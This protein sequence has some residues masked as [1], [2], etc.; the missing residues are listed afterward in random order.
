[1]VNDENVESINIHAYILPKIEY[2][3]NL[4]AFFL[5]IFTEEAVQIKMQL[6]Q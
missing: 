5:F 1:M 6:N 2:I 3:L 4:D